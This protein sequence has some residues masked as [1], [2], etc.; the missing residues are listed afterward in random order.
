MN[1]PLLLVGLQALLK[2]ASAMTDHF[3]C[4][5]DDIAVCSFEPPMEIVSMTSTKGNFHRLIFEGRE[6]TE[7][8]ENG[9]NV[10]RQWLEDTSRDLPNGYDDESR[11]VLRFL[12]GNFWDF[13]K[14]YD[15]IWE[16]RV[17][18]DEMD[19]I[20]PATDPVL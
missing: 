16:D 11:Q 12:A 18:R 7:R 6:L 2:T 9:L 8:E 19:R 13:K 14:T 5:S 17:W 1:K 15:E 3:R 20:D 10:F 4:R